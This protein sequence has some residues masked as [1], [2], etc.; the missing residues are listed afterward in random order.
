M[1]QWLGLA[2]SKNVWMTSE[3]GESSLGIYFLSL[4]MKIAASV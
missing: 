3:R 2:S 1:I 4:A